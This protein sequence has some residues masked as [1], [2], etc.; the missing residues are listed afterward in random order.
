MNG[1]INEA[2]SRPPDRWRIILD[3]GVQR[4]PVGANRNGSRFAGRRP[5]RRKSCGTCSG[6]TP[7]AN[8]SNRQSSHYGEWLDTWLQAAVKPPRCSARTIHGLRG[9]GS[10]APQAKARGDPAAAAQ[11]ESCDRYHTELLAA[12]VSPATCELHHNVLRSSVQRAVRD[13]R[14]RTNAASRDNGA[15]PPPQTRDHEVVR[16]WTA[17]EASRCS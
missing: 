12:G 2:R 14:V 16:A 4:V 3:L 8:S 6:K 10:P 9:R 1:W 11:A 15:S 7:E 5:T 13:G 17:E